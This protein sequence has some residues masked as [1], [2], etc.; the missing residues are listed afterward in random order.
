MRTS[1]FAACVLLLA[2]LAG[3]TA[4]ADSTAAPDAPAPESAADAVAPAT[5]ATDPMHCARMELNEPRPAGCAYPADV[6]AFLDARANCE[7][8][9]GEPDFSEARRREIASAVEETCTGLDTRLE[10]LRLAHAGDA[11]TR[12]LLAALEP[13]GVP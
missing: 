4:P 8:W 11:A 13:L 9:L 1:S 12:E 7:H 5:A 2:L 3:C 6:L 10:A